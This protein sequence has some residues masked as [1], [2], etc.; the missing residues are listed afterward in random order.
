[1]NKTKNTTVSARAGRPRSELT[2]VQRAALQ[3]LAARVARVH[4]DL[5]AARIEL[6][7]AARVAHSEGASIRAIAEVVGLSRPR[8]HEMI[9]A[10]PVVAH[11]MPNREGEQKR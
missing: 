6:A 7:A 9:A 11:A 4:A 3:Q 5:A 8:V 1:M 2:D 10:P